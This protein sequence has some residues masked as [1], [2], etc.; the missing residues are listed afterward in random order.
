MSTLPKYVNIKDND[1][2]VRDTFTRGI[3]NMNANALAAARLKHAEA[4]NRIVEQRRKDDELNTLREEVDELKTAV[5]A[6]L[7]R[8]AN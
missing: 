7:E 3:V 5:R 2:L 4:M 8:S 1:T 6:L